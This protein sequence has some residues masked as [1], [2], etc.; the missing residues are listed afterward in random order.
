MACTLSEERLLKC[1]PDTTRQSAQDIV[2]VGCGSHFVTPTA[3]YDLKDMVYG[4]SVIIPALVMPGQTKE[5]VLGTN[6]ITRHLMQLR[7]Y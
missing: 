2:I 5:M 3:V 4:Y 7:V 6:I 1:I